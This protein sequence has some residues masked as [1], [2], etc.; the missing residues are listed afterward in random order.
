VRREAVVE[1]EEGQENDS[2]RRKEGGRCGQQRVLSEEGGGGEEGPVHWSRRASERA[3]GGEGQR[4]EVRAGEG[5]HTIPLKD[6]SV[7]VDVRKS[8]LRSSRCEC[9]WCGVLCRLD[10]GIPNH[11]SRRSCKQ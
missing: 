3:G 6:H 10:L 4:A 11:T 1:V 7:T 2:S 8:K 5:R 9:C